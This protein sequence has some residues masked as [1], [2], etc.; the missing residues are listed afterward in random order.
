MCNILKWLDRF[1]ALL[2]AQESK[3]TAPASLTGDEAY[4]IISSS[5]FESLG[6]VGFD[7]REA[8][9]LGVQKNDYVLITPTDTGW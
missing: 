2:A 3:R 9:H 7:A 8:F 5:E 4:D 6:V 1:S